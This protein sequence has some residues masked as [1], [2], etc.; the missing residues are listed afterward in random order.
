[1]MQPD[2]KVLFAYSIDHVARVTKLSRSRLTRW[3]RLGFFSPEYVGDDDRRNPYARVYSFLDL[4]GLRTLKVLADDYRVPLKELRR[5]AFELRKRSNRPWSEIP[6]SVLKRRVV[7]DL[8]T[9]PKNVVDGQYILNTVRLDRIAHE[10]EVEVRRLRERRRCQIGQ[11]EKRKFVMRN[12]SV[13]A[14]TR[15]P[16]AAIQSFIRAGYGTKAIL[17]QY[18]TLTTGDVE[19]VRQQHEQSA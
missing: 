3:D 18:P 6:L 2:D 11:T 14:G 16:V 13:L 8:H 5:T 17:S 15:I 12:A 4:L 1:M 7:F 10:V 19:A 9:I